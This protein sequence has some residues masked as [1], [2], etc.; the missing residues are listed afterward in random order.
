MKNLLFTIVML[1]FCNNNLFSQNQ[2]AN[3][4]SEEDSLI[5]GTWISDEDSKWKIVF[6]A[7]STCTWY[8]KNIVTDTY[9]YKLS[10]TSPQC[11]ENVSI[12]AKTLYLS[13]TNINNGD[14]MCYFFNGCSEE[15]LSISYLYMPSTY[16]VFVRQ[17]E[18]ILP[19]GPIDKKKI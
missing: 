17:N 19:P 18:I 14:E 6:T 15:Y 8:Y 10:N 4:H 1:A 16:A 11:G 2:Y 13:L 9:T 5:I 12:N 7:D 3:N